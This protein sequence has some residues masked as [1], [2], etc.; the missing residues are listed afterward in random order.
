M[1]AVGTAFGLGLS[2]DVPDEK[3][4]LLE[5][6]W[7]PSI[8]VGVLFIKAFIEAIHIDYIARFLVFVSHYFI[9][10]LLA[11]AVDQRVLSTPA[12]TLDQQNLEFRLLS[13]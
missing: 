4:E 12:W 6:V 3:Q 10:M 13:A 7:V 2:G 5:V 11:E 9:I 1:V 8:H